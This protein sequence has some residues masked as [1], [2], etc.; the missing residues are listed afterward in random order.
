MKTIDHKTVLLEKLSADLSRRGFLKGAAA[1]MTGAA[2]LG[3]APSLASAQSS[4]KGTP[5]HITIACVKHIDTLDP[6]FTGFPEAI[7]IINNIHNGL[8]KVT[9]DGKKVAFVPDLAETWEIVDDR[10]HVFK[11]RPNVKFHDGTACD[12]A[13]VKFSIERCAKG[14]PKS[15][16][17]WKLELLE[18]IETPD[19]LTVRLTF[20]APYAFLPVA[21]TG[22]TG[23]AGTI[24]SPAAVAKY[25]K[26]YGRNPV[27]TGPFKFVSW[28]EN[29][30]IELVKNP[31]YFVAGLPKLD[32]VTFRLMPEASTGAAALLS[33][34]VQGMSDV[35]PQFVPQMKAS[36]N[37]KLYGE[38]EGNY[39]YLGMNCKKGPFQDANLRLAVAYALDREAMIRQA[40]FG[41]GIPAYTPISPPMTDFYD[42]DVAKSGR[43][44]YFDLDK[45]KAYRA[46]VADQ[47]VIEPVFLVSE[48]GNFGSRIAQTALPMLEK[49]GIKPKIEL[50]ERASWVSRRNAGAFD[51]V[52]FGWEADL[53]PDETLFPEFKTGGP[54]NFWGW[55]NPQ[56]DEACVAA[57]R[58]LNQADRKVLYRKAE[59]LLLAE[60]P[61]ALLTHMPI[62]KVFSNKVQGFEYV[63]VDLLN[64]DTVSLG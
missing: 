34:Q 42:P 63:P 16:H 12:A 55:S 50:V 29:A 64:L 22:S 56:F 5:Q 26:D 58:T 11:L 47:G 4:G 53:D 41:Q 10:I 51:M 46:K 35:P 38:I 15:P 48:Q 43:G 17:A 59:D 61:I 7:K 27:G 39:F 44:Q 8:L 36:K 23:R 25:G 9:Y 57:Q 40:F 54:W 3:L 13:A 32:K 21:L 6:H 49:I 20:S 37:L 24:V 31:D 14:Q 33:G 19:P 30:Q 62:Y 60:P 2:A 1:G 52:D 45:A 28:R 18:S